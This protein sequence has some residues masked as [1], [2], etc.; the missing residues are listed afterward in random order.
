M[1]PAPGT[2]RLHA[3]DALRGIMMLL[4]IVLHAAL[5]YSTVPTDS[6]SWQLHDR[7]RH[8]AFDALI[9]L[10]HSFRMPLFFLLSGYFMHLMLVRRG[11]RRFVAD[12]TRRILLPF[13][14]AFVVLTP[15]VAGS[16]VFAI[17]VATLG[18]AAAAAAARAHALSSAPF[19]GLHLMHLWFLYYLLLGYGVVLL[20]NHLAP[21]L[22]ATR[23]GTSFGRALLAPVLLVSTVL[24]YV[25]KSGS[26]DTPT[27]F[28]PVDLPVLLFY[29]LWLLVGWKLLAEPAYLAAVRRDARRLLCAGGAALAAHLMVLHVFYAQPDA[30]PAAVRLLNAA[31]AAVVIGCLSFGL[32]GAFAQAFPAPNRVIRFLGVAAYWAYLVHLPV[33]VIIA[34]LFQ[35]I[36]IPVFLKFGL[37]VALSSALV[38]ESYVVAARVARA[39]S[40]RRRTAQAGVLRRDT[41]SPGSAP[42]RRAGAPGAPG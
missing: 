14:A 10:I 38:L 42:A 23:A 24:L 21:R 2:E 20:A 9:V 32:L 17:D 8:L 39:A 1:T 5:V 12:R 3:F 22:L 40:L 18:P 33:V 16:F 37:V 34:G 31:L 41:P 4:G 29:L 25:M 26:I 28:A 6:F 11:A 27:R 30:V 36:A 15:V 13:V 35:L 19:A 7:Q